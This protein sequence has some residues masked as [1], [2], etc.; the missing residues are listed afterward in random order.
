MQTHIRNFKLE[1]IEMMDIDGQE[2]GNSNMIQKMTISDLPQDVHF[3]LFKYMEDVDLINLNKT[4]K[5]LN[6]RM[7]DF[8]IVLERLKKE[9][10]KFM[11]NRQQRPEMKDLMP[12]IVPGTMRLIE[13]GNINALRTIAVR[14]G[15][16][17]K[18]FIMNSVHRKLRHR[19]DK[20]CERILPKICTQV[21]PALAKTAVNVHKKMKR[22]KMQN[23]LNAH[24]K[25]KPTNR[26]LAQLKDR[27]LEHLIAQKYLKSFIDFS[28]L[29]RTEK[30]MSRL[31]TYTQ[32]LMCPDIKP[33]LMFFESF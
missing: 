26:S 5:R 9:N 21:D 7:R 8:K 6:A 27:S 30:V 17:N 15:E 16:L 33:K 12:V 31:S 3:T 25:E 14:Q 20:I 22:N 4:S 18:L 11:L 24:L 10:L 13:N 28:N 23:Q 19:P 2:T 29:N 1:M 32:L